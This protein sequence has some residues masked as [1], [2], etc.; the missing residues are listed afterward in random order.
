MASRDEDF[1]ADLALIE[2]E[3][4][5]FGRPPG[6]RRRARRATG[7]PCTS[8]RML[9]RSGSAREPMRLRRAQKSYAGRRWMPVA[10]PVR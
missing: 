9:G 7:G 6:R 8:R 10:V 1:G 5:D 4:R 3:R 2:V